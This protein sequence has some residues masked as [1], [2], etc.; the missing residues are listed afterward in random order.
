[1]AAI[2]GQ[3]AFELTINSDTVILGIETAGSKLI[4]FEVSG[5]STKPSPIA[6]PES[7]GADNEAAA[8]KWVSELDLEALVSKLEK[9]GVPSQYMS[10]IQ[11]LV[12]SFRNEFN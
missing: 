12:T 6:L 2:L 10:M 4:S 8:M 1:M 7:I 11:Q 9:A 3:A 5:Q